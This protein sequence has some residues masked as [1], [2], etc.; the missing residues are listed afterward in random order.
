MGC[1]DSA[2]ATGT[3]PQ[4]IELEYSEAFDG[5]MMLE[6]ANSKDRITNWNSRDIAV[7]ACEPL[8]C[9]WQDLASDLA[10]LSPCSAIFHEDL[11]I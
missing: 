3:I 7:C 10:I 2:A 6:R 8:H 1:G 5:L 4:S 11:R 9:H